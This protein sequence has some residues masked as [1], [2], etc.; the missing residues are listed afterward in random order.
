[1]RFTPLLLQAGLWL[2]CISLLFFAHQ[3]SPEPSSPSSDSAKISKRDRMDL[4][5]AQEIEMTSD[6]ALGFVPRERMLSSHAYAERLRQ[7]SS[8]AGLSGVNW[9]EMGPK[10][11][12]GRTRAILVDP[13]DMS[14]K[15]VFAAGVAGGLWKTTDITASS[16]NWQAV[17]DFFDNLAI[18]SIVAD[19]SNPQIMYFS[20]GEGYYNLDAVR[21]LGIWKSVDGGQN[22]THLTSTANSNFN[23]CQRMIVTPTGT[24]FV[25]TMTGL[26]RS[27]NGGTSW[28]RVLGGSGVSYI[29][30]DVEVAA[31]GDVYAA[32]YGAVHRSTDDGQSF[33][34]LGALPISAERIEIACAPSDA[35]YIYLLAEA[36]NQVSGILQSAN[37]GVT[38]QVRNEPSDADPGILATD[39]SRSQAWYNLTIAVDPND[40]DVLMV[41][42]IDLFRSADGGLNWTQISHWYGG[43]GFQNVHADQHFILYEPGNSS[44]AYFGNDGG[45]YRTANAH[46]ATPTITSKENNYRTIQFYACAMH[47][48]AGS[49]HFLAGAQDNGSH[50]FSDNAI[51]NTIEVTGGDGAFCHIDQDQPN[52]Q[53]TS[54]VYNYFR[55]STNGGLSFSTINVANSGRFIN[56]SD[57]DNDAHIMYSAHNSGEYLRWDDP[58]TGT[59]FTGVNMGFGGRA[60]TITCDPNTANRV[61]FGIDNGRV[62]QVDHAHSA[63]PSATQINA[64]AS[65]PTAY[66]SCIALEEGNANHIL[67][68]YANYGVNSVWETTDGGS[69]WTSVEGNLPDMP[70]RWALF[71]PHNGD[72]ALLATELGVWSTNNLNGS[73]TAWDP[74]NTGLANVRVDMLQTR[75]SDNLVIAA[76]HGRGLFASDVFMG[77]SAAFDAD[78]EISYPGKGVKFSNQSTQATSWL[79][80]FGDGQTSTQEHPLHAYSASGKYE[81]KLTINNGADIEIKTD[82]IHILPNKGANYDLASG[83]NLEGNSD[84]FA[85]STV[86]GTAWVLGASSYPGKEGTASGA[87][88]FVTDL[89]NAYLDETETHLYTPEFDFTQT[90]SYLLRFKGRFSTETG[91]DGFRVEYTIDQGDNWINLGTVAPSW[92]NFSNFNFSSSFPYSEPFFTGNFGTS[93][94]NFFYDV[95]FLSNHAKVAF[96]F[97]FKSDASVN[98][99]GVA[100]DDIELDGVAFPVELVNFEGEWRG[101][102]AQLNWKTANEQQNDGFELERSIDGSFFTP[103]GYV[104][105]KGDNNQGHSYQFDDANPGSQQV[106]Y[107]RLKQYDLDGSFTYLPT[108]QLSRSELPSTISLYPNPIRETAFIRTGQEGHLMIRNLIGQVMFEQKIELGENRLN[109]SQIPDGVYILTLMDGNEVIFGKK[110]VKRM[111]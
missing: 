70:I 26:Y 111:D 30:Y 71:N 98:A 66:I 108:I 36:G 93:F 84:D 75:S 21:G 18:T 103:I 81:V 58:R 9:T 56:P 72:Q 34:S 6:P 10:N 60:S 24:A 50:R 38:W 12:G 100:L 107:Y 73:T 90:S 102:I 33:S 46:L 104:K 35:N 88:A 68:T 53:F 48:N 40:E 13:N 74:S 62:Y 95:S 87:N 55:R 83:G 77:A 39:F 61:Y 59:T 80:D 76:T 89:N 31:N 63:A 99:A 101:Q 32:V 43:F 49:Y 45:I 79:W 86:S 44:V 42:G 67:V 17:N 3:Q 57:Y 8:R 82:F 78:R 106:T 110:I 15:S 2:A 54:Y 37:Q 5:I 28:T 14:Q 94:A 64:S 47:P 19:P 4:A 105:G 92:Y 85:V 69:N 65:M 109:L 29:T 20:T 7:S 97:N 27:T 91:Y 41:G 11:F 22:W 52:Y 51:N 96:R 16:P 25:A 23:Y 1:M